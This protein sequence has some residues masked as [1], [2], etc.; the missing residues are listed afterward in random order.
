MREV[1]F[2]K[3][4]KEKWITIEEQLLNNKQV[5]PDILSDNY[6]T[7]LNDLSFSQTYYPKSNTTIYLNFLTS[8][9]YQKIYKTKRIEKNKFLMFFA[10]DAPN[11]FYKHRKLFYFSFVLFFFFCFL[12]VISAKYNPDFV[13]FI[14]GDGYVNQTL[15]NIEN[16]D[17]MAIYASGSNW[18]S[19]IAI[20]LNNI[21][22]A[23]Y[24][25]ILGI[26][27]G[28]FTFYIAL[29]NAIML[30]SFQYFFYEKG[31]F[32]ESLR[33]IWLHGAVEIFVIIIATA[34]GFV[35]AKSILFPKTFSRFYSFKMGFQDG[36]KIMLSTVPFFVFAGFIEGFVT[37]YYLKMP[38]WLNIAIIFS[39]L[40]FSIYYFL[41][42]PLILNKNQ[43]KYE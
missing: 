38:L 15:E 2:I 3:Q 18:G 21:K 39:S 33:A 40:C 9:I 13:R 37:R 35:L 11:L 25:F 41:I 32:V 7:L 4:N 23:C 12:G 8:Q 28:F 5:S 24:A 19:A 43:Q 10:Q 30:G 17:P 27:A 14:L 1:I 29:N 42:Y 22:V 6:I 26:T 20:T 16:N 34:A 36:I 31:V